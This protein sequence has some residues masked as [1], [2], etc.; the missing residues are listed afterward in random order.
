MLQLEWAEWELGVGQEATRQIGARL[1]S[2]MLHAKE[3]RCSLWAVSSHSGALGKEKNV[4]EI[5]PAVG[6][7]LARESLRGSVAG[8]CAEPFHCSFSLGP[9]RTLLTFRHERKGS[10]RCHMLIFIRDKI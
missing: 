2:L 6:Y 7:G 9:V 4:R 5:S 1:G 8:G 10:C 3:W